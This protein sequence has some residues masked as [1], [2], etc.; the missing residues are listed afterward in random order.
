MSIQINKD[1]AAAILMQAVKD[2][3]ALCDGKPAEAGNNFVELRR[4]FRS[5]WGARLARECN[6][7][8]A[9]LLYQLE[10]E[11]KESVKNNE[12]ISSL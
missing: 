3:R 5:E 1:F 6:I 9:A 4:F 7:S 11:R 2:W 12:N 8:A 10:K